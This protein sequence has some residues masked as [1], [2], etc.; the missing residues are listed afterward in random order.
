MWG[1]A[2][3]VNDMI[4]ARAPLVDQEKVVG[5]ADVLQ[6]FDLKSKDAAAV[7]GCRVSDGSVQAALQWRVI[8][9]GNPVFNG[10]CNSIKRHKLQVHQVGKGTECGITLKDLG[11]ILQCIAIEKVPSKLKAKAA[12]A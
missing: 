10:P 7:A 6:V 11:D 4:A 8:R 3:Q 2:L 1:G 5:Q 9:G 12:T